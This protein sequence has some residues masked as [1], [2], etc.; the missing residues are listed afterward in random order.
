MNLLIDERLI[1]T[2]GDFAKCTIELQ[3]VQECDLP[4]PKRLRA[5]RR[6]KSFIVALSLLQKNKTISF[7]KF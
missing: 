1:E 3:E 5:G 4:S 2:L 7:K 6:K